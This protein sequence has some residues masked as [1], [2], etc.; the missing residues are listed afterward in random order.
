LTKPTHYEHPHTMN[1]AFLFYLQVGVMDTTCLCLLL[2][3]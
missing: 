2:Q 1:T 3:N